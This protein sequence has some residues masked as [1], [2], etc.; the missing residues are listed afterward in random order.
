MGTAGTALNQH[1]V[2]EAL[3]PSAPARSE[4]RTPRI[5]DDLFRRTIGAALEIING[6]AKVLLEYDAAFQESWKVEQQER[7]LKRDDYTDI[8]LNQLRREHYQ[9]WSAQVGVTTMA[10]GS[11]TFDLS[12][13]PYG[14]VRDHYLVVRGA[15]TAV[16]AGLVGMRSVEISTLGMDCLRTRVLPDGRQVL[17][18]HGMLFKTSES[19]NGEETDWVAGWDSSDNPVRLA[20]ETLIAVSRNE[21]RGVLFPSAKPADSEYLSYISFSANIRRF[22][23]AVLTGSGWYFEPHQFRKTF[24]RFVA[25]SSSSTALALMRHFKHVSLQMTERYFPDDPDLINEVIEASESLIAERLDSIFGAEHLGGLKGKEIIE[26][27]I[28]FRGDAHA[29]ERRELVKLTLEDP[30]ARFAMHV[31]GLCFYDEASAKCGGDRANVGMW[32]CIDCVNNVAD[33][34]SEPFWREEVTRL[35]DAIFA[36]EQ[37]GI[38][39]LELVHQRNQALEVLER[40]RDDS[41]RQTA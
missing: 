37:L 4:Q 41:K 32:T 3:T 24:A 33:G 2:V 34:A 36:R 23:D 6:P 27:N 30:A 31:Y 8:Y 29:E 7:P 12:R 25:L 39:D 13:Q 1:Q 40:L 20:V 14:D 16:I 10:L 38:I 21:K 17:L 15:C 19:L 35:N 18:L 28:A 11:K 22:T 26:N 9:T 5:P